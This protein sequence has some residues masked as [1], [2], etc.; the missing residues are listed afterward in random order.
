MSFGLIAICIL[1]ML[2]YRIWRL[3]GSD[4]AIKKAKAQGNVSGY[5]AKSLK[6][7]FRFY[8]H[9]LIATAI[10]WFCNDCERG[11]GNALNIRLLGVYPILMMSACSQSSS[12]ATKSLPSLSLPSSRLQATRS[13]Q[14]IYG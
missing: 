10:G 9:R 11:F 4:R 3:K 1:W 14:I 6:F 5:D 12:T 13:C 8:W 7:A 2:Y